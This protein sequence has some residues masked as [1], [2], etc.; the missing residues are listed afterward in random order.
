MLIGIYSPNP[1]YG[2]T[3]IANHLALN[4]DFVK[5]SFATP[6]KGMLKVF[7]QHLGYTEEDAC[8]ALL[9]KTADVQG[10]TPPINTRHLLRT[11]GTEWGRDCVHP[12]VWLT[13]WHTRYKQLTESG[14]T[15][16]VV[17]DMRF[18]NE[19]QLISRCG[20]QLWQVQRT[21]PEQPQQATHRSEGGLS[22]LS[23][24]KTICN[25]GSIE[26]LIKQINTHIAQN[27]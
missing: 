13:C 3:T 25:D 10:I 26:A 12:E 21:N 9:N 6:I 17:D 16:I 5:M 1:G 27:A 7:L 4:H 2:K 24:D 11:L 14:V 19:A 15:R 23:F 20:G 18:P 22:A 8:S